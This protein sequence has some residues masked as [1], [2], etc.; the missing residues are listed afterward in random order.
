MD[1]IARKAMAPSA[2][3]S[4]QQKTY[5]TQSSD[6]SRPKAAL[7]RAALAA[8]QVAVAQDR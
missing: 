6:A 5:A 2:A 3:A 4:A 8:R 1:E 7:P